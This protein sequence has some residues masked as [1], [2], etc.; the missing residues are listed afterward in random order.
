MAQLI[1]ILLSAISGWS[2]ELV[3]LGEQHWPVKANFEN[4]QFGGISAI[5]IKGEKLALLSD[6]RGYVNE[7]RFYE[8]DIKKGSK[9]WAFENPKVHFIT[10]P[11]T[12]KFAEVLDPESMAMLPDGFLIGSEGDNNKK[13]RVPPRI[14]QVSRDGKWQAEVKLPAAVI[15]EPTGQQKNGISNNFGFEAMTVSADQKLLWFTAERPLIQDTDIKENN[16]R[17]RLFQFKK[18]S[19]NSFVP[20]QELYFETLLPPKQSGVP[21]LH[22]LTDIL[23]YGQKKFWFLERALRLDGKSLR[24]DCRILEM[25]FTNATRV[26]GVA[27]LPDGVGLVPAKISKIYELEK[28]MG[29]CEGF[30]FGPPTTGYAKTLWIVTDNNFSKFEDT[31][32]YFFGVKE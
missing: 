19:S 5:L 25:D 6:D 3:L 16:F 13:P 18:N 9:F 12:G 17:H 32:L 14:F 23:S 8:F 26:E 28:N 1:F 31:I 2:T 11:K 4:T 15:P 20:D 30:A 10:L 7:P 24:Y 27:K 22:G 29:N 21:L